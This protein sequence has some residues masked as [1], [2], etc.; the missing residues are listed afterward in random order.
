MQDASI[1]K[2]KSSSTERKIVAE[3]CLTKCYNICSGGRWESVR[4]VITREGILEVVNNTVRDYIGF[5]SYFMYR[6]GAR[7]TKHELG[8]NMTSAHRRM[9]IRMKDEKDYL[10]FLYYLKEAAQSKKKNVPYFSSS[11]VTTNND[12]TYLVD[13]ESYYKQVVEEI[14]KAKRQIYMLGWWVSPELYLVRPVTPETEK[15]QLFKLL[16][17]KATEGV[18]INIIVYHD[19]P[20]A[21]ANDSEHTKLKLER[22]H[23]NIKVERHPFDIIPSGWSHHEKLIVVDY[24]VGLMGG[25]DVCYG[26][27]DSHDHPIE[28]NSE[29]MYPG[30]DYNNVRIRD[31]VDVK[32]PEKDLQSRQQ[33]RMPWHD[34]AY[35]VKG[36]MVG[37][38]VHHFV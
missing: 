22:L 18:K 19:P 26:R 33:P 13:A 23:P 15:Y 29:K 8:I 9:K 24:R 35:M 16:D 4:V 34:V 27:Y 25:L 1:Y 20:K 2:I 31:F 30:I 28:D 3:N 36:R 17:K 14:S 6:V 32:H 12:I 38:L 10:I 11:M 5:D 21:V 7:D 37:D